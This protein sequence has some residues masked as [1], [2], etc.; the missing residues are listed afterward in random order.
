MTQTPDEMVEAMQLQANIVRH[1]LEQLTKM[2]A[3]YRDTLPAPMVEGP[4]VAQRRAVPKSMAQ[5][6]TWLQSNGPAYR[7]TIA[8]AT[9]TNLA[10]NVTPHIRKWKPHM[11]M[12]GDDAVPQDTLFN[13]PAPANGMGRPPVIYFLWSQR[14]D[15]S[16]KF[17]VGPERPFAT[18]GTVEPGALTGVL[19]PYEHVIPTVEVTDSN[20]WA[21]QAW[22]LTA[23]D[24]TGDGVV[25]TVSDPD[26]TDL[27]MDDLYNA[28]ENAEPV[29]P[30]GGGADG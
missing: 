18:G 30:D 4:R 16:P 7:K 28:W 9:G 6:V 3:S 1:S 20:G 17:G 25:A 22:A 11:E 12:W 15:V 8:D 14:Y 27:T 21:Q 24:L 29:D 26:E 13:I 23:E 10:S 2:L 5:W 19:R